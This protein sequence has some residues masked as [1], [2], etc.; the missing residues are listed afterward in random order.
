MDLA[1]KEFRTILKRSDVGLF[2]FAGHGMQIDGENYLAAVD[3]DADSEIDAKHS[4]LALNRVIETAF[5]HR[6]SRAQLREQPKNRRLDQAFDLQRHSPSGRGRRLHAAADRDAAINSEWTD[7][8]GSVR[9]LRR[10]DCRRKIDSSER[11]RF[12]KPSDCV[13]KTQAIKLPVC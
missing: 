7:V 6:D 13:S 3:A 9:L 4:S 2:F 5:L 10:I 1:L 8:R 11:T 12:D